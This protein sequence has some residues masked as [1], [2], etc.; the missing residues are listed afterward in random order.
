MYS[1][2]VFFQAHLNSVSQ[3]CPLWFDKG[4]EPGQL[5]EQ[6]RPGSL[7]EA[8]PTSAGHSPLRFAELVAE[9]LPNHFH[10]VFRLP[11]VTCDFLPRHVSSQVVLV[12]LPPVVV[13]IRVSSNQI[14]E[15]LFDRVH[16]FLLAN[17]GQQ[18]LVRSPTEGTQTQTEIQNKCSLFP[19]DP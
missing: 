19:G 10:F 1:V 3:H 7:R 11:H 9:V 13:Q 6:N 4:V 17:I 18:M 2:G 5:D 16:D 8:V 12:I 14:G 15:F